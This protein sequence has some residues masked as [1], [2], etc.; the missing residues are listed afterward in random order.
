M[1]TQELIRWVPVTD[2]LP[3]DE[4]T[5]LVF[6]PTADEPVGLGCHSDD[7]WWVT[8]GGSPAVTHW[9]DMPA[10]PLFKSQTQ[11]TTTTP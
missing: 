5:V 11:L 9:A 3:D 10:G 2:T 1:I 6:M 4:T 7:R 8:E